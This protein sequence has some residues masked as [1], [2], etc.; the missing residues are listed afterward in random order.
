ML[1]QDAGLFAGRICSEAEDG[2]LTEANLIL[3]GSAA[4]SEGARVALDLSR[5][6]SFRIF[7]GQ[8]IR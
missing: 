7:P 6:T 8:V 2:R 3:E 5:I 4:T 1:K